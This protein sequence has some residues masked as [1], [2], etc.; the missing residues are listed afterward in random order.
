VDLPQVFLVCCDDRLIEIVNFGLW[1]EA[2]KKEN[3]Q[4]ERK[5]K[6]GGKKGFIMNFMSLTDISTQESKVV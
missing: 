2:R 4:K 5:N 3:R 1:K 6:E